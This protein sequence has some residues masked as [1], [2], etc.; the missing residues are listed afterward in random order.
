[1]SNSKLVFVAMLVASAL[2]MG[3]ATITA[4]EINARDGRLIVVADITQ[5]PKPGAIDRAAPAGSRGDSYGQGG[6]LA[7]AAASGGAGVGGSIIGGLL[8][9][10]AMEPT[11]Y[12][13]R[14]R[15]YAAIQETR[16]EGSTRLVSTV[17]TNIL[18]LVPGAFAEV[19]LY[20]DRGGAWLRPVT[21]KGGKPIAKIDASHP[22]FAAYEAAVRKYAAEKRAAEQQAKT[23]AGAKQ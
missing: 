10:A 2:Q 16:C 7:G 15:V 18:D 19:D 13:S 4:E 21:G 8:F 3:C 22:C 11:Y 9:G 5:P 20:K 6:Q 14:V 1:M 23:K 12:D 17:K